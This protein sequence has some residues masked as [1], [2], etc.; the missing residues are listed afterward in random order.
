VSA[1]HPGHSVLLVPV[2]ALE[3]FV[4]A[5]TRHYDASYVSD[6][7]HFVHAHVTALGPFLPP[8][9]V[10]DD[11]VRD[12]DEITRATGPFDFVLD[13]LAT[14]P[15][16]IVHLLPEPADAF[17]TLTTALRQTFPQCPP[18]AGA[19]PDPVPHLTLDALGDA[20]TESSTRVAVSPWVP[21]ACR[22]ER[23][24]LAWYEPHRCHVLR[25]WRLGDPA[26][27]PA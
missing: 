9:E 2:P 18:Y 20:V 4:R 26:D 12:I 11:V 24:D 19:F 23:L 15:N 22:A 6:D 27:P 7:P 10:T 3:P 13:R 1:G 21:A 5:R 16:G 8:Q 25:S 17:R 14:F